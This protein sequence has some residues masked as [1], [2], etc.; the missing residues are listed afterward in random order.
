MRRHGN[1]TESIGRDFSRITQEAPNV[2]EEPGWAVPSRVCHL[3]VGY[4]WDTGPVVRETGSRYNE[5]GGQLTKGL[6]CRR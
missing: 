1:K 5:T 6:H 2:L 3:G 4:N